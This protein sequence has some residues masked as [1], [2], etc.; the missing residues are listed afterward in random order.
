MALTKQNR[1]IISLL[2]AILT[3]LPGFFDIKNLFSQTINAVLTYIFFYF[4]LG[5][6]Y[7]KEKVSEKTYPLQAAKIWFAGMTS[8]SLLFVL[9]VILLLTINSFT[10][11]FTAIALGLITFSGTVAYHLYFIKKSSLISS[12]TLIITYI[13]SGSLL[14]ILRESHTIK[15]ILIIFFGIASLIF[16]LYGFYLGSKYA[17]PKI[18]ERASEIRAKRLQKKKSKFSNYRK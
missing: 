6:F 11:L 7:G 10:V 2:F 4:I 5:I 18:I 16:M 1:I 3:L 14:F 17:Y 15:F 8:F 12:I 13:L 9:G